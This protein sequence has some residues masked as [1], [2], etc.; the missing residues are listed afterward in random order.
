MCS[1]IIAY[2]SI[3][4]KLEGRKKL[5]N[6]INILEDSLPNNPDLLD[7]INLVK[8]KLNAIYLKRAAGLKVRS[9]ENILILTKDLL[10][11]STKKKNELS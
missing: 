1:I 2:S 11:F 8:L 3:I 4:A 6:E 5:I 9:R 7:N 10:I